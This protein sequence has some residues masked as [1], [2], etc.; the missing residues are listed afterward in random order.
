MDKPEQKCVVGWVLILKQRGVSGGNRRISCL[1]SANKIITDNWNWKE[2]YKSF[3]PSDKCVAKIKNP[4]WR[5]IYLLRQSTRKSQWGSSYAKV[6]TKMVIIRS[7]HRF[8][9]IFLFKYLLLHSNSSTY[10]SSSFEYKPETDRWI[11]T[12]PTPLHRLHRYG[13]CFQAKT[14]N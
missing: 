4:T 8:T 12:Y 3:I 11:N 14:C 7:M 5:T 1:Y 10:P 6:P 13:D 9:D 2:R